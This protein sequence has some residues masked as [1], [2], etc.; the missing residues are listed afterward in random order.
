[1]KRDA[2]DQDLVRDLAKLLSETG[3]TELEVESDGCRIKVSRTVTMA[4]AP[5][6]TVTAVQAALPATDAGA[7]ESLDSHPGAVRAPMVGTAYIL[8]E[9]GAAPFVKVGDTIRE[10]QILLLIEAMKT[11]NEIRAPKAGHVTR[12]LVENGMPVEYGEP[13]IIVE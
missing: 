5:A 3:L 11:F 13:L 4:A 10:G 6:Q 12:I 8:P 2:I 7:S 1:M 9:P